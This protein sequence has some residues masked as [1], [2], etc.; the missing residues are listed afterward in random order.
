M[1]LQRFPIYPITKPNDAG[2]TIANL[3]LHVIPKQ[4]IVHAANVLYTFPYKQNQFK[5]MHQEFFNLPVH[6]II[7]ALL[8]GQLEGIPFMKADL[9]QKYLPPSTAT[10]KGQM[11][12]PCAGIRHMRKK[13]RNGGS[14]EEVPEE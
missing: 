6:T 14:N 12:R 4:K 7:K 3:D 10:P 1:Q 8:N 2:A 5:Y 9:I 13:E 11:N